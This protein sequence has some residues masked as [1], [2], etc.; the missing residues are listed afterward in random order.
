MLKKELDK[1]LK[2]ET[3]ET[4]DEDKTQMDFGGNWQVDSGRNQDQAID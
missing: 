3:I 4:S 1:I 2:E